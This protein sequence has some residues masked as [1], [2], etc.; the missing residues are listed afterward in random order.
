MA[1][2]FKTKDVGDLR[3]VK[4]SLPMQT[5]EGGD[6]LVAWAK[7]GYTEGDSDL[8]KIY[9]CD[10]VTGSQVAVDT[11]RLKHNLPPRFAKK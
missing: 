4:G 6:I 7:A 11:A 9:K 1:D 2:Q 8:A 5:R 3:L 10:Y